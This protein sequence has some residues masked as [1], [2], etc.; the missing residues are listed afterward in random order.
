MKIIIILMLVVLGLTLPLDGVAQARYGQYDMSGDFRKWA[1][2]NPLD[3]DYDRDMKNPQNHTTL[4]MAMVTGKYIKLWDRELNAI[5]QKLL[6]K[7]NDE[8]KELLVE[9]QVGWLQHHEN[10]QRFVNKA[11]FNKSMGS[12]FVVQKANAYRMRLRDRTLELME[13][14]QRLGGSAEFEYKGNEE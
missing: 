4:G 6:L 9:S 12:F 7:L 13:Y 10:E 1:D 11:F 8:E 3:L 2:S 5:Y 14:Y